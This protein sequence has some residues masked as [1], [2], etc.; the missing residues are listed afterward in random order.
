MTASPSTASHVLCLSTLM[1]AHPVLSC[2]AL[3][4]QD[5]FLIPLQSKFNGLWNKHLPIPK[6]DGEC[7][8]DKGPPGLYRPRSLPSSLTH[9]FLEGT[10]GSVP[11]AVQPPFPA[12][13]RSWPQAWGVSS[14]GVSTRE[15]KHPMLQKYL[16]KRSAALESS[17]HRRNGW[18]QCLF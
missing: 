4:V 10:K 12:P 11:T 1:L 16:Y 14:L 6:Q 7:N 9:L 3:G 5:A 15:K 17:F 8:T 13:L 18:L 2:L